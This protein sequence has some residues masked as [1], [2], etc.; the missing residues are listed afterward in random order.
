MSTKEQN[1]YEKLRRREI[2]ERY[3]RRYER[4]PPYL[5]MRKVEKKV[6]KVPTFEIVREK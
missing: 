5:E 4:K 6:E 2:K 1:E 3:N